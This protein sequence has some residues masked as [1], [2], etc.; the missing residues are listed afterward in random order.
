MYGRHITL[1]TH[2]PAPTRTHAPQE[3]DA[4]RPESE[5]LR[6]R[7]EEAGRQVDQLT[8]RLNEIA[9]RLFAPFSK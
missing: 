1:A 5:A 6:G 2:S 8:R 3:R 9:D 7:I 4:K